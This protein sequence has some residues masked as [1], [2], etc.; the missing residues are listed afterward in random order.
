MQQ[1]NWGKMIVIFVIAFLLGGAFFVYLNENSSLAENN[2]PGS[3]SIAKV[4]NKTAALLPSMGGTMSVADITEKSSPAIVN[5]QAQIKVTSVPNNP[6]FN[7]PFFREFFGDQFEVRPNQRYETGIGT[8]FIISADG[9]IVTNQH[10]I[11]KAEKVTVQLSGQSDEIP[12]RIVGQDYDLDLAVLKI[13]GT[14]YP[15]LPLGNSDTMRAGDLVIAIG[16]P[17]GLDHTVT[18][19]VI[20]AKGRPISIEDRDYRN[21]I[22]TDA[23]INPGNSG[24]PLLNSKGQVI[25]INTAV[26]AQAQGIGFAIPINTARDVLDELRSG[27]KIVKPFLGIQMTAVNQTVRDELN[28]PD[29]TRGV[30]V[31]EVLD[32]TAAARAGI[33]Q[34]DIV[35]AIEG[36]AVQT[37]IEVQNAIASKKAGEKITL[38]LL[39]DGKQITIPVVLQAKP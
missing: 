10:V 27:K 12:A 30:I 20:S 11:N 37:A 19:G 17:F 14:D 3:E 23:A 26:N 16:Q 33:K 5:I 34:F 1:K 35:Q 8:G 31:V 25:G 32:G 15:T 38:M 7:D 18:V 2:S 36:E 4:D 28:L 13:E 24:G 9:Y 29:K 6:F 22:Q 21:L 39:R